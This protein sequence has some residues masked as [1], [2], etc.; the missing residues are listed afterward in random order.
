MVVKNTILI[1]QITI[2]VQIGEIMVRCG[3]E[4]P[5][6]ANTQLYMLNE[7]TGE[8]VLSHI[9]KQHLN[10]YSFVLTGEKSEADVAFS[11][12]LQ[13]IR[14][15]MKKSVSWFLIRSY[16]TTGYDRVRSFA[17]LSRRK[18]EGW[19]IWVDNTLGI[20]SK[21]ADL[22]D[23]SFQPPEYQ[24]GHYDGRLIF[25]FGEAPDGQM[26]AHPPVRPTI[27]LLANHEP[28][29]PS[30]QFLMWLDDNK[31]TVAYP[32]RGE[33]GRWGLIVISPD[34]IQIQELQSQGII[35]E[36]WQGGE[37]QEVWL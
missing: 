15:T 18:K 5:L 27:E 6:R 24:G 30:Q 10:R 35:Q 17:W 1:L 36:T 13:T 16:H 34:R 3:L 33:F 8:T 25:F 7:E 11:G 28:L 21:P 22:N 14:D 19:T 23:Q 4:E 9:E 32:F 26:L 20:A 29:A 31:Y 2:R 12:V 37:A